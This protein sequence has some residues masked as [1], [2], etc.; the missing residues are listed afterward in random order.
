MFNKSTNDHLL[1]LLLENSEKIIQAMNASDF[2]AEFHTKIDSPVY[3]EITRNLNSILDILKE[4]REDSVT[5][6]ELLTKAIRVGL[7]DMTVVKGDPV[8]PN[9]EFVW[10]DDFRRM[11]GF[12]NR[13][14]FPDTL[15]SWASRIQPSDKDRVLNAFANHITDTTGRTPYDLQYQLQLKDGS[16]RWFRATGTTVRDEQG[17]G[18]RVFGAIFDIHDAKMEEEQLQSF[19]KRFELINQ[20]LWEGPWDMTV[21]AGDPVNPNNEFWWSP[22]FRK[23]LGYSDEHDFPNIMSS[24]SEKIHPEDSERVLDAFANHLNDYSGNTPYSLEYRLQ[25]KNGG[26]RWFYASGVTLRNNRGIPQRVA[27]T[28]RDITIEKN[29]DE[30]TREVVYRM[31]QLTESIREMVNAI[32]SVTSHALELTEA[33]QEST[34]AAQVAQDTANNS[35]QMADIIKSIANQTNL[36]GLNAAIEAARAGEQ[37]RGFAVVS[38]EVRKLAIDSSNA[39]H[40]IES[41]IKSIVGIVDVIIKNI[42]NMN[43]LTQSQA[44]MTQEV[45]AMVEEIRSTAEDLIVFATKI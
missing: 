6:L 44:A 24:W 19:T 30:I 16:Y 31:E 28:I 11:L 13:N 22:Q 34:R 32:S 23:L 8:N 5:R 45:N 9:N 27:G 43:V 40:N 38:E 25:T 12:Q 3:M 21:I 14:D 15:D 18:L 10:S 39:V 41:N 33:Q 7:W 20:V 37:G 2:S 36:L 1:K 42:G 17:V 29:K 35:T 4:S 26:Y